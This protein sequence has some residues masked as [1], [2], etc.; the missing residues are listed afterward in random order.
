MSDKKKQPFIFD[1]H[2][3]PETRS[4]FPRPGRTTLECG[5]PHN[6]LDNPD[7]L[8]LCQREEAILV[9]ADKGFPKHVRKYQ[10]STNHCAW[11]VVLLPDVEL[12]RV[13][14]LKR[15][16]DGKIRLKHPLGDDLDFKDARF[17]NLLVNLQSNPPKVTELC[18][19]P[20]ITD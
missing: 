9:T 14:V 13:D 16:K 15:L 12:E 3:G 6:A 20:W 4:L 7:I 18:D 17:D 1:V 10:K 2:I 8:D 5:L 19:C 11:G